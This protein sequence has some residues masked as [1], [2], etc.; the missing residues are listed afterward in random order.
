MIKSVSFAAH[1]KEHDPSK[2]SK[3]KGK[4]NV[5]FQDV[6]SQQGQP[7]SGKS[8]EILA[9]TPELEPVSP[10]D[11]LTREPTPTTS[12]GAAALIQEELEPDDDSGVLIRGRH[13]PVE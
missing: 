3:G 8:S 2:D 11:V 7:S 1:P 5:T 6:P 12:A 10:E 4:A 13:R 9:S